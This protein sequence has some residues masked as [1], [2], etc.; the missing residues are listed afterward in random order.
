MKKNITKNKKLVNKKKILISLITV[1]L[2]GERHLAKT[3]KSVLNQKYK[4]FEYIIIDG[5]SNDST[6]KIIRRFSKNI[7][8]VISEKDN[9]IYDAFNKGISV[10]KG[11]VIGIINSDDVYSPLALSY[12]EKYFSLNK[13]IDF[14]FGTVKK[15]W[16]I[17]SGYT[18]WTIRFSWNF[19]TSHS[20]GFFIKLKSAKRIGNYTLRYKYSSDFDYFYRMIVKHK[21]LGM[22]SKKN[23]IFGVFRRGGFSSKVNFIDHL[24]ELTKIRL[25]NGQNKILVL[26]IMILKYIKNFNRLL[27]NS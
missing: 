24:A 2:N 22:A 27:I 7:D 9:G 8:Y 3:I 11:D 20:V 4:N 12:V 17:I 26:M 1:V 16:K 5:E 21:M 23:E 13:N 10:A 6:M 14:L 18:P 15:H 25:N 19:Y